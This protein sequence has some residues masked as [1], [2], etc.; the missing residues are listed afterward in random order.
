M[1][2]RTL[3]ILIAIFGLGALT[4]PHH[5]LAV[6]DPYAEPG[7]GEYA[8]GIRVVLSSD[9]PANHQI[10]FTKD[11]QTPGCPATRPGTFYTEPIRLIADTTIKALT[12]VS[13]VVFSNVVEFEY[14]FG[15]GSKPGGGSSSN[16]T[17]SPYGPT[18]ETDPTVCP[19][20]APSNPDAN[21]P[22]LPP[23]FGNVLANDIS[24]FT[25]DLTLGMGGADVVVLQW[26]L[27]TQH[28]GVASERLRTVGATGLFGPLTRDA[29]IEFQKRT[30]VT[31]ASGYVGTQT[32]AR[33]NALK[34]TLPNGVMNPPSLVVSPP[35]ADLIPPTSGAA[36]SNPD[37]PTGASALDEMDIPEKKQVNPGIVVNFSDLT[38]AASSSIFTRDIVLGMT[39]TDVTL[40]Q[41][42]LVAKGYLV[43]PKNASYGY[44][45]Q[46]TKDAV[47][48]YMQSKGFTPDPQFTTM[49]RCNGDSMGGLTLSLC[50][51]SLSTL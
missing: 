9:E 39:G 6:E 36:L 26:F 11:G 8:H 14:T 33:I 4:A 35:P 38:S 24:A 32:R 16:P 21:N 41:Q 27:I 22:L 19:P 48:R 51:S 29:V 20:G 45:G 7:A 13:A 1:K 30:G 42:Y 3:L 50:V 15:G 28:A 44:F 12:C 46:V 23:V 37:A 40:V 10:K 5:A 17:D 31:P 47:V 18:C 49:Y 43:M 25:R 34:G 2:I